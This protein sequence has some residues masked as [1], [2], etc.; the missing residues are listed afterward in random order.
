M[1]TERRPIDRRRRKARNV[2]DQAGENGLVVAFICNHCPYVKAVIDRIVRDAGDLADIGVGFVAISSN[3]VSAYPEDSFENMK[4]FAEAHRFPFPYLY[5]E[6]QSVARHG[7]RCAHLISSA[8]TRRWNCSIA[9]GST[10]RAS[11]RG[12][13]ISGGTSTRQCVRWPKPARDRKTRSPRW[14]VRSNGRKMRECCISE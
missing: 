9:A 7:V 1:E 10:H 11:K 2:L 8:S 13:R 14:G 4:L 5:D 3:D 6:D 12:P